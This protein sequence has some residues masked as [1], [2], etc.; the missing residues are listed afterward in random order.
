MV[1]AQNTPATTLAGRPRPANPLVSLVVPVLN[2]A[3]SIA[4]FIASAQRVLKSP[5]LCHEIVF[6]DDGSDDAT[7]SIIS[8]A[9]ANT[10]KVRGIKLSRKFGKEAAMT[11]GIDV[12][13]GDVVVPID[14][15]LQDPP[16]VI[17]EMLEAW[18]KGFDVV[19]AA[20]SSRRSDTLLKRSVAGGFYRVFNQL[21]PLTIPPD[22]GD[23]QLMDRRVVE[24][25][26][27]LPERNRFM[28][29]LFAWV[30]FPTAA[31]FFER[32]PR[33]AGRS[34]FTFGQLWNFALDGIIS[35]STIPLKICTFLG[36]FTALL[37]IGYSLWII[38]KTML[39]GVDVPGYASL[40]SVI[41]F[42]FAIQFLSLG[43]LGEYIGRLFLE[44]KQRPLYLI[45]AD[46]RA[47][48]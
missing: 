33:S 13:E 42:G 9:A 19:Y 48:P 37:A 30:G 8:E 1:V 21:S 31:V 35:F 6:I 5:D 46:T 7:W 44:A 40:M 22:V 29:E 27:R 34:K 23:F 24:A 18:R 20:R 10:A 2:E 17:L 4:L 45:E 26:K 11:A 39:L 28:K 12:A 32:R 38:G 15:D 25:L 14:V 41:L 43:I 3:D 47:G 36:L 16:E